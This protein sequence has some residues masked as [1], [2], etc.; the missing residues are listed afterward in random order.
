[1]LLLCM[2]KLPQARVQQQVMG[3]SIAPQ[4]R[5]NAHVLAVVFGFFQQ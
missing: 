3:N 1:M 5:A 2:A 4:V